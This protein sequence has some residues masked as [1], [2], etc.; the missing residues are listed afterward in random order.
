MSQMSNLACADPS[1]FQGNSAPCKQ[2][3]REQVHEQARTWQSAISMFTK[4]TFS[5]IVQHTKQWAAI[6]FDI[7]LQ[8]LF[9]VVL[10][11]SKLANGPNDTWSQRDLGYQSISYVNF[12]ARID[13]KYSAFPN[14]GKNR[15]LKLC[16]S[17]N[18][19]R[20]SWAVT[21]YLDPLSKYK[22]WISYTCKRCDFFSSKMAAVAKI[23]PR[24]LWENLQGT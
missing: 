19:Y 17:R 12:A 10:V 24:A 2:G 7:E 6:Q 21:G 18:N 22:S 13:K 14:S 9:P 1:N 23:C 20:S 16:G 3:K 11:E 8:S 15:N 4:L 5:L